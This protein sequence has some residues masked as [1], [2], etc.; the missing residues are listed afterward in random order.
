MSQVPPPLP[1]SAPRAAGPTYV[2]GH[3]NPDADSICSAIAYAEYKRAVG[4][5]DHV[6]ARCG[7]SNDRIEAILGRFGAELP[8]FVGD[9]TPRVEDIMRRDPHTVTEDSTC[10]E[11][12]ELLD[13][14][15]I[16]ALPVVDAEGRLRGHVS[17]FD[18]GDTFIPKPRQATSMRR[19]RSSVAAIVRTRKN[20]PIQNATDDNKYNATAC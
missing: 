10:A 5:P 14:H 13:R 6:A 9:V 2:I 3:K 4:Q 11:A 12:L 19:V 16:R 8:P 18:L 1:R 15:D 20:V 17:I 7:N